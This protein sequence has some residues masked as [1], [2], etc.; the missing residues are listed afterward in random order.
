MLGT[1][2]VNTVEPVLAYIAKYSEESF[3]FDSIYRPL[4]KLI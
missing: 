3:M 4:V 1:S 2:K